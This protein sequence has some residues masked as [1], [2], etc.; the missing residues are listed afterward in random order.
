MEAVNISYF[1]ARTI[2]QP[3]L[4]PLQQFSISVRAFVVFLSV[5]NVCANENTDR[6]IGVL[7][8]RSWWLVDC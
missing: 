5:S 2:W 6:K 3:F 4:V 8:R 7:D 1:L